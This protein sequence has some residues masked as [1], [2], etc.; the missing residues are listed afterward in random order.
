MSSIAAAGRPRTVRGPS[1]ARA[2]ADHSRRRALSLSDRRLEAA[3]RR[4]V[5]AVDV[6][7]EIAEEI[8]LSGCG[9]QHDPLIPHRVRRLEAEIGRSA[10][11]RVHRARNAH[12]LH[13]ALMDWQEEL[14]DE[15]C[16]A[17]RFHG[18]VDEALMGDLVDWA[19]GEDPA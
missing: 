2:T 18:A 8:N 6:L 1:I 16:P 7:V 15:A 3:R 12:Q 17:R 13:A 11:E 14:L 5:R 10:P 9:R 4:R 19:R